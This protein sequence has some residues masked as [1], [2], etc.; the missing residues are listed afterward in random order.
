M[1]YELIKKWPRCIDH[2][3]DSIKFLETRLS[4]AASL[5][6]V[7]RY[8]GLRKVEPSQISL[9]LGASLLC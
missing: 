2:R 5:E 8:R 9:F 7:D 3:G 4:N 1:L 6:R